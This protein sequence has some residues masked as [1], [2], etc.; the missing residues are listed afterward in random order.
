MVVSGEAQD[1]A[2]ASDLARSFGH[3]VSKLK[4]QRLLAG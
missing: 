2:A 1:D 4:P 3:L